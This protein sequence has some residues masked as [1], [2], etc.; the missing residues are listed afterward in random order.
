MTK[1]AKKD[2][3]EEIVKS[4]L[5]NKFLQDAAG[6]SLVK[7][8]PFTYGELGKQGGDEAYQNLIFNEEFIGRKQELYKQKK[9]TML[10]SGVSDEPSI[11]DPDVL[12]SI[13][14][15]LREVMGKATVGELREYAKAAGA[16]LNFETPGELKGLSYEKILASAMEKEAISKDRT[17]DTSKLSDIEKDAM[18]M[19]Q[20]C[21]QAYEHACAINV[22]Q[23]GHFT[24]INAQGSAIA[25][26]Y[27]P[28]EKAAKNSDYTL[29]A[30]QIAA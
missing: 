10:Q 1:E 11:S 20:I 5:E 24:E 15:Q 4:T 25:D 3:R 26:K 6:G 18:A 28:K 2:G 7:S 30:G 22:S 19:Y 9:A 14:N 17:L 27:K 29:N 23:K 16:D 13:M 21:S 8:N 12:V